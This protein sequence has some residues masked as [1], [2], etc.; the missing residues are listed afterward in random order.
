MVGVT[1]EDAPGPIVD[2]P[3]PTD[4]EIDFL[5]EAINTALHK[6]LTRADVRGAFAGLRPLADTGGGKTAD[7]SRK[8]LITESRSG[9]WTLTAV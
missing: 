1:D 6:P 4:A 3:E 9:L 2:E 5:L 7:L 8:H